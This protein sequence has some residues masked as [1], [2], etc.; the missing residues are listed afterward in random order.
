MN[1]HI[2]RAL[3]IG[4][5]IVFTAFILGSSFKNRNLK[6]DTISVTGLGSKD[7]ISDE[8][9]WG[10][11]F[12]ANAM[13]ARE[14][15]NIISQDKE[16]VKT[17]FLGKGF[18]A[19]EFTFGGVNFSRSYRTV[20]IKDADGSERSEDVFDG[21]KATQNIFFRAKKNPV[22][23]KKIE[24][25]IDKTAELIN[26]GVQFEP[27][28]AQY[29]YS[30]LS[31]LKHSLIE[32]GSKDAKER[33]EKIVKAADGD[34]GKLKDASMGV[35]QITA[36]GSTDEDSYGGNFDTSSKEKS[37]RITVRLTYNLD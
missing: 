34:L 5:A 26:S 21:Y 4:A 20:T 35:F 6:Q 27:S 37:A 24:S 22:F 9:S 25:V 13:D 19:G 23:M 11:S 17:F 28:P 2:I 29:T 31:S 10:G 33:A 30:D 1:T 3:I 7:F 16:K 12:D 14:A 15:Y 36:K 32:A 8:M 18:K